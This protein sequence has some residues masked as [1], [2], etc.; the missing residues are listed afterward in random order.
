[1]TGRCFELTSTL[2][3]ACDWVEI[4]CSILTMTSARDS[5]RSVAPNYASCDERAQRRR[6]THNTTASA[7]SKYLLLLLPHDVCI[8]A[9]GGVAGA[10]G[11]GRGEGVTRGR[12][13]PLISSVSLR[14]LSFRGVDEKRWSITRQG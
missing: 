2:H 5:S 12:R 9:A 1:V 4:S 3:I 14:F 7:A 10:V 11:W 8:Y 6:A 13:R